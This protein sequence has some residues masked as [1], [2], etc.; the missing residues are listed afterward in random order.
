MN[1]KSWKL[2]RIS[3]DI[4][5]TEI[6]KKLGCSVSLISKYETNTA[7]MDADKVKAYQKYITD[8]GVV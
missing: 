7:N 2:K 4:T 5:I 8:K 3:K 1:R 6:A